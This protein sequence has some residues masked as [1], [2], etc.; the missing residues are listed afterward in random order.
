MLQN[1]VEEILQTM[2]FQSNS[3]ECSSDKI[4]RKADI[5]E[6]ERE[7]M[8]FEMCDK[9]VS[10]S[11]SSPTFVKENSL[12][13]ER[14]SMYTQTENDE[15]GIQEDKESLKILIKEV[16]QDLKPK[17]DSD[18]LPE[19]KEVTIFSKIHTEIQT[20][21]KLTDSS[22]IIDNASKDTQVPLLE[23]DS[24]K[25]A[26]SN[27]TKGK[28]NEGFTERSGD[29]APEPVE[30]LNKLEDIL[31]EIHQHICENKNLASNSGV[32]SSSSVL[33][34]QTRDVALQINP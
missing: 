11:C 30:N 10:V 28:Q 34:V 13:I 23:T 18:S 31:K 15:C 9:S 7:S 1:L 6:T 19:L 27:Q 33:P 5:I 3:L 26:Y 16:L 17:Y 8:S 14:K 29:V 20:E 12:H 32:G 25:Q 21:G 22:I 4:K 2:Q 24:G